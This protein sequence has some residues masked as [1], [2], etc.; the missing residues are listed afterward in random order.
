[1]K[2]RVFYIAAAENSSSGRLVEIM[3]ED[4]AISDRREMNEVRPGDLPVIPDSTH[5]VGPIFDLHLDSFKLRRYVLYRGTN[6]PSQEQVAYRLATYGV[7][8]TQ[9]IPLVCTCVHEPSKDYQCVR[10]ALQAESQI[11]RPRAWRLTTGGR[12]HFFRLHYGMKWS[13]SHIASSVFLILQIASSH[14]ASV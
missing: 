7:H 5:D 1:M 11:G 2:E 3:I 9:C 4:Q 13:T 14:K 10:Q 6:L 12:G 8:S